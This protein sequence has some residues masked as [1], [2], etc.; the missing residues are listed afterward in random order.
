MA[1]VRVR[2]ATVRY[3]TTAVF[4]SLDLDV[5]AG[6]F[7]AVLGPNGAGKTTLLKV[8]LGLLPLAQGSVEIASKAAGRANR[9]IGYVPQQ[10]AF[11]RT[12]PIRGRDLV[13]FGLDGHRAGFPLR[14]RHTR[15]VVD[16][17]IRA[18]GAEHY[19]HAPIGR[20]SG[21]E[22]QRL[23]IAQAL[24]TDPKVLLCDEPLLSLDLAQQRV[25]SELINER[26]TRA[27]T[28]VLFVTHDINPVLPYVDRVLYLVDGRWDV[29]APHDV[30]TSER[31][32]ELYG[33]D[34][35]VIDVRGRVV[36][37]G[38]EELGLTEAHAH[39]HH[40]DHAAPSRWA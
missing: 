27:S 38:S 1:I 4:E 10:H 7:L 37:L 33:T 8:L 35:E 13:Q 15:A 28:S 17:A 3:G 22:Q 24:V 6:E 5:G 14:S 2:N 20:L 34:V 31:L 23:R 11:D 21:G 39:H 29:G 32:T 30:L 25:V 9:D 16:E 12:L 18:V 26:R 19:A 40:S 36:V